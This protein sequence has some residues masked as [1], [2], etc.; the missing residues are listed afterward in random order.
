MSSDVSIPVSILQA[1]LQH[2]LQHNWSNA[3]AALLSNALSA[4]CP[5]FGGL[6]H[7]GPYSTDAVAFMHHPKAGGTSYQLVLRQQARRKNKTVCD[8]RRMIKNHKGKNFLEAE[9][10]A[11]N[12]GRANFTQSCDVLIGHATYA[13]EAEAL[14]WRGSRTGTYVTMFRSPAERA[15]SLFRYQGGNGHK[16]VNEVLK[17]NGSL[18]SEFE[19]ALVER[20]D[21][22]AAW[23]HA[24]P[25]IFRQRRDF[26]VMAGGSMTWEEVAQV[27]AYIAYR[28]SAVGVLE[29]SAESMEVVRCRVPWFGAKQ[30]PHSKAT[31]QTWPY[32][33]ELKVDK[34]LMARHVAVEE[35]LYAWASLLLTID[36]RCCRGDETNEQ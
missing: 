32:P 10:A 26:M 11:V 24:P 8:V 1:S 28:H 7:E 9:A 15:M 21:M 4:R 18:Q 35:V 33:V 31:A 17:R 5:R 3:S 6:N 20:E 36:L 12:G 29:R 22:T 16:Y 2:L 25:S 19:K 23:L 30:M 13:L 14:Q 34:A 27:M